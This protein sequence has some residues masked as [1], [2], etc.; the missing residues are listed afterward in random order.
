MTES[1]G[2]IL[3][4]LRIKKK[5]TQRSLG[6]A[7]DLD[8]GFISHIE[9]GKRD[10]GFATLLRWLSICGGRLLIVESDT[11]PDGLPPQEKRLI[12]AV[13][14][15]DP[16]DLE[17]ITEMAELLPRVDDLTREL[18]RSQIDGPLN[19]LR[20]SSSSERTMG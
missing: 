11:L 6:A 5:L 10:P 20:R 17:R 8:S 13:R 7:M 4:K 19:L 15:I 9:T 2:E 18:L 1:I 3:R 12:Q 16:A 14:R